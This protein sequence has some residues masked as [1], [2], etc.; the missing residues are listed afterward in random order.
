[1]SRV[2]L[3]LENFLVYGLGGAISKLVPFIMLPIITRLLPNTE[4]IGINDLVITIV[5][6]GTSFSILGMYDAMF[7]LFF[8]K[9]DN[10]YKKSVC[11][12]TL[13]FTLVSSIIFAIVLMI[14]RDPC[15]VLFF[16]NKRYSYLIIIAACNIMIGATNS[17]VSAPTRMNNQKGIFLITNSI[18]PIIS[19]CIS[20]PLIL[21]GVYNSALPIASLISAIIIELI[22]IILNRHY[23][24]IK[25]FDSKKLKSLLFIGIPLV[26]NFVV[27]WIFNSSDRIMI[28]RILGNDWAGIYGVGAR[29]GMISQLIYTA[30]A[31]GWQ[32]F[33]FSTMRDKDQVEVTSKVFEYLGIISFG[34]TALISA[35]SNTLFQLL[36]EKEY[37]LGA[38][39]VPYLFLAPLLQMLFQ[40]ACN[41]FIV[42]KK[43]WPNALILGV[44]A[45]LNIFLNF[46]FIRIIG[47]EGAAIATLLGYSIS[48][49]ICVV[50]LKFMKLIN[51]SKAFVIATV[52]LIIYGLLWRFFIYNNLVLA[53]VCAI[54]VCFCYSILYF[55][56]I[57]I[58]Y[59]R[60]KK[61]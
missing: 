15:S 49:L 48:V 21:K 17:I 2:K 53:S 24:T 23:F 31:G 4:Y 5:S 6:F 58:L 38:M 27:Y 28:A 43:T 26:P 41:Q 55:R 1:M 51:I 20:I 39:V 56:D 29:I 40:V 44:G 11:S 47:I 25:L 13:F 18:T 33:A 52:I 36:F 7:R 50:V 16:G 32:Y 14:F 3:F 59:N 19:Y 12:T 30:F 9:D 10:I 35:I 57:K 60:L 34:A 8:E 46:N 54:I 42:I 22:F 45:S 37:L 61:R